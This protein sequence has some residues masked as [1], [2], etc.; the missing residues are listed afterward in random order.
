[1]KQTNPL[2][3]PYEVGDLLERHCV[4]PPEGPNNLVLVI[5]KDKWSTFFTVLSTGGVT[6]SCHGNQLSYP[7]RK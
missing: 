1:M 2:S 5:D 7:E 6:R 4:I 3:Y